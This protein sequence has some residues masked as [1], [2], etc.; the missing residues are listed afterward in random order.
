MD[1]RTNERTEDGRR[2]EQAGRTK[3]G[4][5]ERTHDGTN[6]RT[7]ERTN[8]RTTEARSACAHFTSTIGAI[9]ECSRPWPGTD[10]DFSPSMCNSSNHY[11][12]RKLEAEQAGEFRRQYNTMLQYRSC[13][14]RILT[15][16]GFKP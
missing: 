12:N 11:I 5:N 3:E 16:D 15:T 14:R 9:C 1:I 13:I 6:G 7:K 2:D 4:T 10:F 8:E